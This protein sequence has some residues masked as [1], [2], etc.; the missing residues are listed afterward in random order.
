MIVRGRSWLLA[1]WLADMAGH[2][3]IHLLTTCLTVCTQ[4]TVATSTDW[5]EE[6]NAT[7]PG[8]I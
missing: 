5:S 6:R 8:D 3:R 1:V 2:P 4:T 7:D